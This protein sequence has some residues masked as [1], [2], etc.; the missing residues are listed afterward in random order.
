MVARV[1]SV[2]IGYGHRQ[3][4]IIANGAVKASCSSRT[5]QVIDLSGAATF[6]SSGVNLHFTPSDGWSTR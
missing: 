2:G 4:D 6:D 3:E 5:C 1:S